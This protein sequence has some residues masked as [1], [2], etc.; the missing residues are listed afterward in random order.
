MIGVLSFGYTITSELEYVMYDNTMN[1][2]RPAKMPHQQKL[3]E[4]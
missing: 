2:E 4:I 1:I 3:A